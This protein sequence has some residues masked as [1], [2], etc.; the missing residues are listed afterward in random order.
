MRDKAFIDTNILVYHA[1]EQGDKKEKLLSVF[2]NS[3]IAY[4]SIQV[5]NEFINTNIKKKLNDSES[6]KSLVQS[7]IKMFNVAILN[8]ETIEKSIVNQR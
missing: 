3:K 1:T 7:Y 5:L 6:I 4:I 2:K 8:T